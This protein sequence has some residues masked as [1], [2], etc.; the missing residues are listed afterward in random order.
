MVL[1]LIREEREGMFGPRI[2]DL[3]FENLDELE[4]IK[5][6]LFDPASLKEA[7]SIL[8]PVHCPMRGA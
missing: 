6:R 3:F 2:V 1:R 7:E 5:L 8:G 4:G